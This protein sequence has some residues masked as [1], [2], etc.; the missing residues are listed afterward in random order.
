M[1][2]KDTNSG[3]LLTEE[4]RVPVAANTEMTQSV[5]GARLPDAWLDSIDSNPNIA[6]RQSMATYI[7]V[8]AAD[9]TSYSIGKIKRRTADVLE[10]GGSASFK[11][12]ERSS[13]SRK[14][15]ISVVTKV[16]FDQL[17]EDAM[18]LMEDSDYS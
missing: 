8:E 13:G 7:K 17:T 11:K 4:S 18:K 2:H 14:E 1:K 10:P 16:V 15:N 12:A 3:L 5:A 9:L 6:Q